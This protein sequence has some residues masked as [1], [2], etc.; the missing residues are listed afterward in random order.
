MGGG[1]LG[2]GG[3]LGDGGSGGDGGGDGGGG[4]AGG[5]G[6]DGYSTRSPQS[7][8]SEPYATHAAYWDPAPPSS[9]TPSI[10]NWQSSPQT[11]AGL[12]GGG[13]ACGVRIGGRGGGL[14]GGGDGGLCGLAMVVHRSEKVEAISSTLEPMKAYWLAGVLAMASSV[15]SL[16][17][18]RPTA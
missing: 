18:P 1:G 5:G 12:A 3:G 17:S 15:C 8:Q 6:G 11:S 13:G 14:G 7:V 16:A 4:G 2:S 9:Q 10:A